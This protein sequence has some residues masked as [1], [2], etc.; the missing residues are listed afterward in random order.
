MHERHL[1]SY[2][3]SNAVQARYVYTFVDMLQSYARDSSG[4]IILRDGQCS[5][6]ERLP[7]VIARSMKIC[8]A[9]SSPPSRPHRSLVGDIHMILSH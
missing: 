6:N 8:S 4:D 7:V 9:S 1:H 5:A 3:S 2:E